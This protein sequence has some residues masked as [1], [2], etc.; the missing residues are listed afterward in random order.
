MCNG[1]ADLGRPRIHGYDLRLGCKSWLGLPFETVFGEHNH[2]P[3]YLRSWL[4]LQFETGLSVGSDKC[5]RDVHHSIE[6]RTTMK[7]RK[8]VVSEQNAAMYTVWSGSFSVA[9][10]WVRR[11]SLAYSRDAMERGTSPPIHYYC[12]CFLILIYYDCLQ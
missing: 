5:S 7:A 12:F 10:L 6:P 1:P 9:G 4:G 3:H 8:G 11:S 2:N